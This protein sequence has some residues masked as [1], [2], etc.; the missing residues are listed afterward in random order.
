M[1]FVI[2]NAVKVRIHPMALVEFDN[3]KD[4][5]AA[6]NDRGALTRGYAD[7]SEYYFVDRNL[8]QAACP[9]SRRHPGPG[10]VIVQDERL[11]D[12]RIRRS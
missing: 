7:K 9:A 4:E 8:A 1:E 5:A 3:L 11:Q 12:Q 6:A 10:P 2:D